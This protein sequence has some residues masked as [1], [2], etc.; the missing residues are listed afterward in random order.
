[1][2]PLQ[3]LDAA[4]RRIVRE[5]RSLP[6]VQALLPSVR[7]ARDPSSSVLFVFAIRSLDEASH[8]G[9]IHLDGLVCE[10]FILVSSLPREGVAVTE[11]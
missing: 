11:F 2:E 5:N 6:V 10:Y 1:M 8:G 3:E 7:V 4:R 9:P